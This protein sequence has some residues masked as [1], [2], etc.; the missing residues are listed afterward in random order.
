MLPSIY[1]FLMLH[2]QATAKCFD[3][4][5]QKADIYISLLTRQ[6]ETGTPGLVAV[7]A[8]F[9]SNLSSTNA[10]IQLVLRSRARAR[11]L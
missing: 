4:C 8:P 7:A 5:R 2:H 10:M 1:D 11:G 6:I 9:C 3:G